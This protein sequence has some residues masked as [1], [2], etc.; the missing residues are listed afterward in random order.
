MTDTTP[1]GGRRTTTPEA[2]FAHVSERPV[3]LAVDDEPQILAAIVDTLEDDCIVHT[4]SS[5]EAAMALIPALPDLSVLLSDQR[6]PGMCGDEL[7][8]RAREMSRAA[9]VMVTGYAD[10]DAV[11][12][13]VNQG[14]IFG[15]ITKPWNQ[16]QLRLMVQSAHAHYRLQRELLAEQR[17]LREFMD[18]TTDLVSYQ[19]GRQRFIRAN[20]RYAQLLGCDAP[21]ALTGRTVAELLPDAE[22]G[23]LWDPAEHERV[24]C[25]G[26]PSSEQCVRVRLPGTGEWRWYSTTRAPI[27]DERD[28][29]VGVVGI[30]RDVTDRLGVLEALRLRERAIEASVNSVTI[31]DCQQPDLPIVYVNPAFERITGYRAEEA[32]GRN[33]RFLHGN[34]HDQPGLHEIRAAIRE[35]RQGHAIF[36]NHC[37]DGRIY[38]ADLHIAPVC[39]DTGR[40]T[41]FVGIQYDVTDRLRYQAELERHANFD[42]VTGVANRNLLDDRLAQALA[43]ANRHRRSVGV[44]S[45]DIDRF[46]GIVGSFGHVVGDGI[47]RHVAARLTALVREGDTVARV[48]MDD[49]VVVL[50]DL[51]SVDAAALI[52]RRIVDDIATPFAVEGHELAV[53]ASMGVCIYPGDGDSPEV[54]LQHANIARLEARGAG[55]NR[56]C[57]DTPAMNAAMLQRQALEHALRGALERGEFVLHY[58]PR[59]SL[60]DG[61]IVGMEA[62]LR[63]QHPE[64]GLVPPMEFIPLAEETGLIVPIGE[65]VLRAACRQIRGWLD[66]GIAVPPVAINLSARQ[67]HSGHLDR[68]IAEALAAEGLD[69][70]RLELEITESTAMVDVDDAVATMQKLKALGVSL[71]LDDFGTGYSSLACLKRF[72]L[73]YLKI[74]RAFVSDV[75]T[76]PGDAAICIATIQLAHSLRLKVIAEG[77]EDEFQ[78]EYLRRRGCDELQGYYFSRPVA[79]EAIAAMLRGGVRMNR[80]AVAVGTPEPT[81]LLV[82]DEPNVLNALKRLLRGDG[83]R[84]LTAGSAQEG[85]EILARHPVHVLL[86]DERMPGMTGSE[87]LMRVKDLHPGTVRMVLSGYA[88]VDA[89]TRA[90]NNGAVSKF[91]L[92]PWDD[93]ELRSTIRD[94]FARVCADEARI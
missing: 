44:L 60:H 84:I 54:L 52:V 73:D 66:D 28:E 79:G 14:R 37:K 81:L 82:D 10:L 33:P 63:W 59:V 30:S 11:V 47:L 4:V 36:R 76:D 17:L 56:Y 88:N 91:L 86:S 51:A 78:M 57:F 6:M 77:V 23:G 18:N 31:V 68:M 50:G 12:R 13:A 69:A 93:E 65:W 87:F 7:L 80:A 16:D 75:T 67:F 40:C 20:R 83:Y 72:P 22:P 62:L 5:A 85:L 55:G 49:F 46:G 24:L 89:I 94:A 8:A 34:D 64:L 48:G 61:A 21:E 43:N 19:D 9:A 3:V 70:S 41:H 35:R 71:A 39:D 53:T 92:K 90:I 29:V 58:Q 15:Y 42:T 74:D 25:S 27:R 1:P 2:S 45:I 26:E 38:W 32:V